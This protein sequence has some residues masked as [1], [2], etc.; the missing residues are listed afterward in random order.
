MGC[1][2]HAIIEQQADDG[3]WVTVNTLSPFVAQRRKGGER[4]WCFPAAL[5][6]NHRRFAALAGVRGD[7]PVPR[8]V[9]ADVSETGRFRI[10]TWN[11]DAHSH[12]WLTIAEAAKVFAETEYWSGEEA[13]LQSF[14]QMFP[15]CFFFGVECEDIDKHRLVFWFTG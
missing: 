9:P 8:G 11:G 2:I 10:A 12:G 15:A 14:P 6:R 4:D 1:D 7:G 13:N 3:R 5:D